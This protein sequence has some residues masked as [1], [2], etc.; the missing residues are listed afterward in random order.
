MGRNQQIETELSRRNFMLGLA[1]AALL[2]SAGCARFRGGSE[3]DKAYAELNRLLQQAG[4]ADQDQL[5]SIA[6]QIRN[7]TGLL[8]ANY[9]DFSTRFNRMAA[10][11][12][13]SGG[14]LQQL[15]NNYETERLSQRN[16]LFELQD[17]L[18]AALPADA[19]PEVQQILNRKSRNLSTAHRED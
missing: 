7:G 13:V 1:A 10:D 19:W 14:Q 8:L 9:T 15:V 4:G 18:H 6:S 11:R 12:S 5:T 2:L 17:Q 16:Q 3:L